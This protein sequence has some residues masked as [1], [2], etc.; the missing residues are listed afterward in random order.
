MLSKIKTSL[1]NINYKLFFSLLVMGLNEQYYN[2]LPYSLSEGEKRKVAIAGVLASKP[3]I[4]VFDEPTANLDRKSIR[5]FFEIITKFKE[6]GMTI[7]I[8]SHD[9][10]LAYEFADKIVL[11]SKGYVKY[12]GS[13]KNAFVDENVLNEAGLDKP[14][15]VKVKERLRLKRESRNISQLAAF[16]KEVAN[17]G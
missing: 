4:L 2:R 8:V 3:R 7:I 16:I 5:E 12:F 1:K 9:V 6:K 13:Y 10:D 11:L 17:N 15:V 14:F